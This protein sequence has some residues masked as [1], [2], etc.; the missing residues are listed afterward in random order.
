MFKP[1]ILLALLATGIS[2]FA[3]AA[4]CEKEDFEQTVNGATQCLQMRRYGA[5]NPQAMVIWLHGDVSSGGPA[6]YHFL[7]AQQLAKEDFAS[8]IMSIALVRPGYPDG[9][10]HTSGVA[11][12]QGGRSDHYT[13]DNL[14]EVATAIERLRARYKPA[15]LIVAAHSGGA[16]STASIIGMK[17]GL[18]DTALLVA[19]PCDI[20]AW[21][22]SRGR[23]AWK[24]SE[25]PMNWTDKVAPSTQ[26]IALTG[27]K[28]DNTGPD[29]A[30]NYVEALRSRKIDA[31]FV[32]LPGEDHNSA[33]KP[34]NTFTVIREM[35]GR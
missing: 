25:N 7:S 5:E 27:E 3:Q 21:R 1:F 26:V 9:D 30:R 4:L 10:G 16:A 15:K 32:L 19:C 24:K 28:D 13:R 35:Q 22:A 34:A 6:N 14:T 33:F 23:S 2:Q 8:K 29:L 31:R 20:V 11:E 12:G 17:P 18:I